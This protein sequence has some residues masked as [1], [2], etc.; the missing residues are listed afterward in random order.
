MVGVG[1]F[2][3]FFRGGV[4]G[5]VFRLR[6]W[7]LRFVGVSGVYWGVGEAGLVVGFL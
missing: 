6:V 7:L 5:R 1:G 4:V 2:W 3:E